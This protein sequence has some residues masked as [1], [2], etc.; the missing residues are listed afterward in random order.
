MY[1]VA[2]MA[3]VWLRINQDLCILSCF[4]LTRDSQESW[5]RF[6]IGFL[7]SNLSYLLPCSQTGLDVTIFRYNLSKKLCYCIY[8]LTNSMLQRL[9]DFLIWVI[10]KNKTIIIP[11]KK[12]KLLSP[13]TPFQSKLQRYSSVV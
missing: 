5:K 10:N 12:K 7:C 6:S 8:R 4:D 9:E 11:K 13:I 3:F 2:T 1:P